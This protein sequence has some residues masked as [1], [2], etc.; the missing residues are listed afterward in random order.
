MLGVAPRDDALTAGRRSGRFFI[1]NKGRGVRSKTLRRV[2]PSALYETRLGT[3]CRL[4]PLH[5]R[6]LEPNLGK[7]GGIPGGTFVYYVQL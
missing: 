4:Q 2:K 1:D 5:T 3:K 6:S 7:P